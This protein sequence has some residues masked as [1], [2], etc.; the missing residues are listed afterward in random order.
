ML[1]IKLNNK[2]SMA[3]IDDAKAN[4]LVFIPISQL[5]PNTMNSKELSI[6]D[7]LKESIREIGL[8]VPLD[9]IEMDDGRYEISSGERRYTAFLSLLEEDPNF[10]Y[11]WKGN[12]RISPVS[13]GIPCTVNRRELSG[14][15]R[16]LIRLI[17][18]KARDYDP[19]EQY[20]LFLTANQ[21][22]ESK[23]EKGEI[24]RGEGRK[25]EWLA[26][27]LSI[28]ERT[29]QKMLDDSWIISSRNYSDVRKA[30]SFSAYSDQKTSDKEK[31]P[32]DIGMDSFNREYMFLDKI[33]SHHEKLNLEKMGL[34]EYQI[35]DLRNN[36]METIKSIMERYGIQKKDIR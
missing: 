9:V 30:G 13:K 6:D 16:D 22:Y 7:S 10:T 11:L 26:D 4:K 18:N 28:S 36:A 33:Q 5:V 21:A 17:G 20:N 8:N 35:Q 32:S 23:K 25:R 31:K 12:G 3:D 14:E 2:N 34:R 15:D 29:I 19:L 1:E 27:Y 24:S